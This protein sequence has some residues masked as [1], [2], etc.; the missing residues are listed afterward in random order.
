MRTPVAKSRFRG[1]PKTPLIAVLFLVLIASAQGGAQRPPIGPGGKIGTMRL[2]RGVA[3]GADAK[4]F[5][6][7]DPIIKQ[8]G[9]YTRVCPRIPQFQRLFVGYGAF[10]TDAA[11][12][13]AYW[14]STRWQMWLDGHRVALPAFGTSDRTPVAFP[15]AGGKDATLREWR[16]MLVGPSRGTHALRYRSRTG[17][18]TTDATWIFRIYR[19]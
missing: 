8:P 18:E 12:L 15:P 10:F 13:N 5:D 11:E 17:T 16:V 7:C 2:A 6:F 3:A 9:R 1:P 14:K 19:P 4:L